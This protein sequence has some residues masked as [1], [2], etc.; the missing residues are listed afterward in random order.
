[1]RLKLQL[2]AKAG[3]F[4][5]S[6]CEATR[7][8]TLSANDFQ[9]FLNWPQKE[10]SWDAQ[11][12]YYEEDGK[13]VYRGVLI[14][15]EGRADGVFAYDAGEHFVYLPGAR[16]VVDSI[17]EQA[18]E[19]II[20]EGTEN[21]NEGSW[22]YYFS[23]LYEQMGLVI[24]DG[25]GFD[26]LLLEKLE[27]RPEAAEV[28][29]TDEC[30]DICY[31]LNYCRNLSDEEIEGQIPL[32]RQSE[33]FRKSVSVFCDMYDEKSDLY[34]MLHN[35]LG[36]SD[37]EI[38]EM[39]LNMR[40]SCIE[41]RGKDFAGWYITPQIKSVADVAKM[42]SGITTNMDEN[43]LGLTVIE[44]YLGEK[45]RSITEKEFEVRTN[46]FFDSD[47]VGILAKL[48]LTDDQCVVFTRTLQGG[49]II[50]SGGM[51][52]RLAGLYEQAQDHATGRIDQDLF[53][54]G[55]Y[56]HFGLYKM[57]PLDEP[58]EQIEGMTMQ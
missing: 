55:L 7:L 5:I 28:A 29:L 25:N 3:Q 41:I 50:M 46:Q 51:I 24:E 4:R 20:K 48:N 39:G 57:E 45:R 56:Q 26:A 16:A 33:L 32:A 18:V 8:L 43:A 38:W 58:M 36:M 9:T 42:L 44:A 15:G 49:D 52:S 37:D 35:N 10:L 53:T 31:Y 1:M 11:P 19:K 22:C 17:L 12:L 14:L 21:T 6:E 34:E 27:Q 47:G 23:E 13:R 40:T 54:S 30:F 2:P